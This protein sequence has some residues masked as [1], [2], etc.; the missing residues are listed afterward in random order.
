VITAA[1]D[2]NQ[3][4]L[5]RLFNQYNLQMIPVIDSQRRIKRVVTKDDL[6]SQIIEGMR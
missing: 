6:T 5:R 1:E 4:G 3:D 2:V